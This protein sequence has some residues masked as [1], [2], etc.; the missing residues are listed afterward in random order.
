[1]SVCAV[2]QTA[3][4][5]V[6]NQNRVPA[7]N[8]E[9]GVLTVQLELRSGVWHAEAEDGPP[10]FV[11]AF[12]ETGHMAQVPGPL[13]RMPEGTTVHATVANKL[14]MKATV[15][16]LSTRPSHADAGVEIAPGESHEF[17]FLVGTPG[18]YYYWA[19]TTEILNTAIR[20]VVQPLR[21]DAQ[22]NGAFIVD[23][24]RTTAADRI[25]VINSMFVQADAIHPAF[26]VLSINGKIYPYTEALEYGEGERIRWRVINPGP[27]EHPMHLHGSFY[28]LLSAG[29][30]E[31]DTAY[32]SG[33]RQSVVTDNLKPGTTM[34]MEWTPMHPG[35]W[36]FHCHLQAHIST[37]EHVPTF[38]PA[39]GEASTSAMEHTQHNNTGAM[40]DMAGLVLVINVKAA[41]SSSTQL[42]KTPRE[43][44][45][46]IE[47]NAAHTRT[48]TFSCS[49]REGRKIVASEDQSIGAQIVLTRG[50]P[51]E[52]TIVNHL[53]VPTT[54]HWHGIELDSYYD[55]VVGGGDG[56]QTTPAIEPG[57][58]F[59]ARFTPNRAGTFIYHTHSAD[60]GQLSGGIYGALIVLASG[61]SFDAEHDR[62]LVIGAHDNDF[63]TTR[64]TLNGSEEFRSMEFRRGVK[65]RLRVVN[66]G[67]NLEVNVQMGAADHPATWRA[68]AKDGADLPPRLETMQ[69][70]ALHIVSGEVYDFEFQPDEA[71]EMQFQVENSL[72]KAKSVGKV[73]VQ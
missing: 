1:M 28:E 31:S 69:K 29:T 43:I 62:V 70:A 45:L 59:V 17:N 72:N 51:T 24:A 47:K 36:L 58:N 25:F 35:R 41:A 44:D 13:L 3:D 10:L 53:D 63:Y 11:Q 6:A 68:I 30:F 65:Y 7:G 71:G 15:Y 50:Q 4:T 33:E 61:E 67:P 37:G 19:R 14:K 12:S 2:A 57:G 5:I 38:T 32:A 55:G 9:R 56:K 42:A 73:F 23:P 48:P 39:S 27:S 21:T 64:F 22:M 26:E 40:N 34:M 66:I 60:P 54:I 46:V 49:V 18:T 8:L 16:G 52:I 20:T